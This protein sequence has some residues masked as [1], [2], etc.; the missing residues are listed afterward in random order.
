MGFL[1]HFLCVALYLLV[2]ARFHS[3]SFYACGI[4]NAE[5]QKCPLVDKVCNIKTYNVDRSTN[6]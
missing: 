6:S 3:I 5:V 4:P 1:Q 2:Y